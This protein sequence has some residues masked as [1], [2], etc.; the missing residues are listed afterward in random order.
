[1][2]IIHP[3]ISD[4]LRHLP[5]LTLS[6]AQ[7]LLQRSMQPAIKRQHILNRHLV[8]CRHPSPLLEPRQQRPVMLHRP[9]GQ[10]HPVQ[11][12]ITPGNEPISVNRFISRHHPAPDGRTVNSLAIGDHTADN[13]NHPGRHPAYHAVQF[14][15]VIPPAH[16]SVLELRLRHPYASVH[17]PA[18]PIVRHPYL[19]GSFLPGLRSA[20]MIKY[21]VRSHF[22]RF[23]R[24]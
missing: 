23:I 22:P 15:C 1:M 18:L 13:L 5:R 21:Y 14:L 19:N 24:F 12:S 20:S 6:V 2:V 8:P 17:V 3:G 10:S 16:L 4:R 11:L 9:I 7:R